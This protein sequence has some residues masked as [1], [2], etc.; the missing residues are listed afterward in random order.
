MQTVKY[1]D[2]WAR[3]EAE[4]KR[5]IQRW[6]TGGLLWHTR[7]YM[8]RYAKKSWFNPRKY[9]KPICAVLALSRL[10]IPIMDTIVSSLIDEPLNFTYHR[11]VYLSSY[12]VLE[13]TKASKIHRM[14]KI[15]PKFLEYVYRSLKELEEGKT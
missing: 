1:E 6:E 2:L 14:F 4:Y 13:P 7:V 8:R 3:L 10:A 5:M 15:S 11:L 9:K 12:G